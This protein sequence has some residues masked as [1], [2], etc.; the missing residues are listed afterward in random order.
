M[1]GVF[2][3]NMLVGIKF[4]R[5]VGRYFFYVFFLDG[6]MIFFFMWVISLLFFLNKVGVFFFLVMINVFWGVIEVFL[7]FC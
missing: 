1:F 4:G 3:G 2:V 6:V 7:M 5:K